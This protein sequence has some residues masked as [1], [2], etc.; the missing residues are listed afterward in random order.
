MLDGVVPYPADLAALYRRKG[1][2]QDRPLI[3]HFLEA[4]DKHAERVAMTADGAH[5]TYRELGEKVDRLARH[6]LGAGFGPLDRVVMQ[7]PNIP[8]FVY[9]YFALQRLGAIP[10]LALPPHR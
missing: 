6:L 10:L 4:F 5:V 2:W 7:L 8:E 9:L 3:S 1:Y